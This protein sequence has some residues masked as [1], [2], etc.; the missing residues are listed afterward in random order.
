MLP[1]VIINYIEIKWH[2]FTYGCRGTRFK[3]DLL[4]V[5]EKNEAGATFGRIKYFPNPCA[6][7]RSVSMEFETIILDNLTM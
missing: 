4:S 1:L 6:R 5:I 3:T 2:R 7:G